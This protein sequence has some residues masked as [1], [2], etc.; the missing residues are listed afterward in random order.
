VNPV[1]LFFVTLK[2]GREVATAIFAIYIL[3][4]ELNLHTED[5]KEWFCNERK[6][7]LLCLFITTILMAIAVYIMLTAFYS[8]GTN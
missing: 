8:G 7:E 6:A 4:V 5:I 1:K 2:S 3:Q